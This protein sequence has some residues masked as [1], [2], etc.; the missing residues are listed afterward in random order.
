[1]CV[2]V[3]CLKQN[4][5]YTDS[6]HYVSVCLSICLFILS[7]LNFLPFSQKSL[8]KEQTGIELREKL[9]RGKQV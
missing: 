9:L 6:K 8:W 7:S 4:L 3:K 2:H 5:V 1:M